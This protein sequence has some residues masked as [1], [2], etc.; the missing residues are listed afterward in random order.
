MFGN[1]KAGSRQV[2]SLVFA[3]AAIAVMATGAGAQEAQRSHVVRPGDTLWELARAYLRNPFLWPLIY[4]ANRAQLSS[5]H[6]L[7][8]DE[9]LTIPELVIK[10]ADPSEPM[11]PPAEAA[12]E[13]P[14]ERSMFYEAAPQADTAGAR[15]QLESRLEPWAVSPWE[16]R[17]VPWIQDSSSLGVQG[18]IVRLGDPTTEDDLL[19]PSLH[20]FNEVRIGRLDANRPAAGDS[21]LV[22]RLG[23]ELKGWGRVIEPMAVLRVDT[24]GETIATATV[25]KQFGPS[26][27]GDVVMPLPAMPALVR[28]EPEPVSTGPQGKVLWFLEPQPHFG[29][30]DYGFVDLGGSQLSIGDELIAYVPERRMAQGREERLPNTPVSRLRVIRVEDQTA[31]VRVVNVKYEA[32]ERGLPVQ[33]VARM[34]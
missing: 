6:L 19:P 26:R 30:P 20:P 16:W 18:R 33:V 13:P 4:E 12:P 7:R 10:G 17:S 34:R 24:V 21:L 31:T 3:W 28:G 11:M 27:I 9:R 15:M 29:P 25:V 1:G 32:L 5:P 14:R 2:L 22:V 8:P 23:Q